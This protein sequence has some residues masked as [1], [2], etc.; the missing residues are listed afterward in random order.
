MLRPK[1]PY[2]RIRPG[3]FF[4]PILSKIL[5]KGYMMAWKGINIEAVKQSKRTVE[6]F[7]LK[8]TII[9]AAAEDTKIIKD[10]DRRVMTRVRT[11]DGPILIFSMAVP[12]YS[13]EKFFGRAMGVL[14]ISV[15]DLKELR[16][17]KAT[18]KRVKRV[19]RIMT[20]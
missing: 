13:N 2:I 11:K 15:C 16:T 5:I 12:I 18:G 9:Q 1:P 7:D 17:K 3:T 4:K 20:A 19:I 8:R 6:T 14:T 10:T